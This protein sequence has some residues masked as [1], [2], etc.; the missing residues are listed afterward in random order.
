[1]G[2]DKGEGE[3][4]NLLGNELL[5]SSSPFVKERDS[6]GF[7]RHKILNSNYY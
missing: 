5:N 7:V 3:L 6:L 4:P 1:V 2:E